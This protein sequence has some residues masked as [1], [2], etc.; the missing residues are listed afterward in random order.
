MRS[1]ING[2]DSSILSTISFK[3]SVDKLHTGAYPGTHQK[4]KRS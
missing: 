2:Q 3:I 4:A 1:R